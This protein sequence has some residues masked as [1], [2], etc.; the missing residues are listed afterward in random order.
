M[1]VFTILIVCFVLF[2]V[3]GSSTNARAD[4]VK[5]ASPDF[6]FSFHADARRAASWE[7]LTANTKI[8]LGN[9]PEL[10]LEIGDTPEQARKVSLLLDGMPELADDGRT[11][12]IKYTSVDWPLAVTIT[13]QA[14][15]DWPVMHKVVEVQ[16]AG[17]TPLRLL[18]VVLGRYPVTAKTEGG[19]RGFP[20]YLDGTY[21]LSL[22]HPAGFA[23]RE[24]D[25]VVLRQ[26]PGVKLAPG[27]TFRSMD[28]IYG[29]AAPGDARAAFVGY[30]RGHMRRVLRGHDKPYAVLES[31]GGQPDGNFWTS[32][33]FL[34][35]HLEQVAQSKRDQG[36][37]FDFYHVDFWHDTAGDLTTFHR[38]NF[39]NGFDW[40][41]DEILRQGMRPA[42]WIDSGGLPGWTIGS[43]PAIL[44]CYTRGDGQGEL[45]RASE[46]I[47]TLYK[48]AFDY[49]IRENNVGMLK[50][51]NIGPNCVFPNCANPAHDHLPGPLYSVEA[52]HNALIDFYTDLDKKHPDV[53]LIL[54]WGYRSPWW[55]QYGDMYFESGAHIE[56][57]SPA[58]FPTPYARDAVTQ[59]LDQAQRNIIDTPWLGKNSLGIWLSDWSWN[60]GIGKARWQ[61]GLVM[62]MARGSLFLEIWTDTNWLTP[63]EREQ[64]A[65]F[66]NLFKAN[67][68][69]FDNSRFIL[70]DPAK[71]EPYGYSCS[72]GKKAFFSI[73]NA[74]LTDQNVT[75]QFGAAYGLPDGGEWDVYRWYPTPARLRVRGNAAG[76]SLTFAM[77]PREVVLLEVVPAGSKPSLKCTLSDVETVTRYAEPT[78][79]LPLVT[80]VIRDEE[81]TINWTA[82]QPTSA[83]SLKATTLTINAD[84]SVSSSGAN[85]DYDTYTVLLPTDMTGITAVLLEALTDEKLPGQ[86]PGRA[87]NGNFALTYT[88]FFACPVNRPTEAVELKIHAA[89]ADYAQ[90]TY[91]GWPI[92]AAFD[93]DPASGWSVHPQVGTSHAALFLLETPT[94]FPGGTELIIK[95]TQG[96]NGHSLGRFRLSVTTEKA[97]LLPPIYQAGK[98]EITSTLPATKTGG[99]FFLAGGNGMEPPQV[100][101][102][103]KPLSLTQ[104]WSNQAY[105]PCPWRA[106][107]AE[108]DPAD[109]TRDIKL[110]LVQKEAGPAPEFTA[111]YLPK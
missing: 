34:R 81:K 52:I 45:C 38:Q 62:D 14:D 5:V 80:R 50:F 25:D 91:G 32:E 97:P 57:A 63:A 111:Y 67:G 79:K 109:A 89:V 12:V 47:N 6:V 58:E 73:N 28:A 56:G 107:R 41:R 8:D 3:A 61:E 98:V 71:E 90:S 37:Q 51:D 99:L 53:F 93:G 64:V 42:L 72:N 30:I 102:D 2:L 15:A 94:G 20:L 16:N 10:E 11:A 18:T 19:E 33:A 24:G 105:W 75:L 26:Y 110:T 39:P 4:V 101:L 43:N 70:G 85:T 69:C 59:R 36:V 60:S 35:G 1:L 29:V 83:Q 65:T 76:K 108:I 55:L 27:Q 40:T 49:H 87:V 13:Y 21:F 82:L 46:P 44:G 106:Y 23:Q 17:A 7:N 88:H 96:N 86:G 78:R 103:D 95:L 84:K 100:L 22:A 77:R 9:G 92:A 68:D 74:S 66:I 48:R 104:V 31:F 54:Y